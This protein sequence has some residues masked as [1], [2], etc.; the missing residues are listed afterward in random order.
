MEGIGPESKHAMEQ[1]EA[2]EQEKKQVRETLISAYEN[3][4]STR[5]KS[6]LCNLETTTYPWKKDTSNIASNKP[7]PSLP[8]L[9]R[10]C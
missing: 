1:G 10:T 7:L 5:L 4:I 3:N 8:Y 6:E 2:M 9:L